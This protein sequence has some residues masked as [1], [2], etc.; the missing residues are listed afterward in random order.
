MEATPLNNVGNLWQEEQI[1]DN[2][3]L[4]L[5]CDSEDNFGFLSNIFLYTRE[6]GFLTAIPYQF[7]T[8]FGLL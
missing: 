6:V 1:T 5:N 3:K 7:G 8:W 4:G 2:L